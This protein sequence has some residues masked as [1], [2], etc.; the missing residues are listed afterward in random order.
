LQFARQL[1][2]KQYT[3]IAAARAP[4]PQLKELM[5]KNPSALR[6]TTLD[7]S[8]PQSIEVIF[9]F[10]KRHLSIVLGNA[11]REAASIYCTP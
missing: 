1:L 9:G 4:S 7:V 11:G 10:P 5:Q 2:Q 6:I 3:V 8:K